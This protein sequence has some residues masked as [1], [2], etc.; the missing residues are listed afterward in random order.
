MTETERHY[1]LQALLIIW[2][3]STKLLDNDNVRLSNVLSGVD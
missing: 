2:Q 3:V 1:K